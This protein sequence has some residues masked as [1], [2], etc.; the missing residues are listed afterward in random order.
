MCLVEQ[1]EEDAK[2]GSYKLKKNYC[3]REGNIKIIDQ[4]KLMISTNHYFLKDCQ[5]HIDQ[6][7]QVCVEVFS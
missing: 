1:K 6:I 2:E 4:V 5:T 3:S 7:T